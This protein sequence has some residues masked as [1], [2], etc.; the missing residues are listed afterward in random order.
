M[1][2]FIFICLLLGANLAHAIPSVPAPLG[3]DFSQGGYADGATVTG[4]FYGNDFDGNGQLSSFSGEVS[5]FMMSFSGN[6]LVSAFSLGISDLFGLVYDLDG[7]PLGDGFTLQIEGIGASDGIFSYNA[8]P[9]P[10]S[11]AGEVFAPTGGADFTSSLVSVTSKSAPEP[12]VLALL[13]IGFVGIGL[14][15]RKKSV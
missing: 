3:F 6:S 11:N 7:G 13:A 2:K 5:G 10:T 12:G 8:G 9:G 14:S 15:R 4:M 1:K